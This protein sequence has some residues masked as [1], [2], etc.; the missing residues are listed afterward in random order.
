MHCEEGR[1]LFVY[2]TNKNVVLIRLKES[3]MCF[4]HLHSHGPKYSVRTKDCLAWCLKHLWRDPAGVYEIKTCVFYMF[5]Y[6]T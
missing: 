6:L 2:E 1:L 3:H 4:M 5:A